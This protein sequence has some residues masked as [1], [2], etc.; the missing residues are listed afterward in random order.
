MAVVVAPENAELFIEKAAGENLEAYVVAEITA[1]A[2][3]VMRHRGQRS[4][5]TEPRVPR[6]K[7]RR[8]A[9]RGQSEKNAAGGG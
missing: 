1:D 5:P 8:K 4:W 6:V 3:M 9:S 7:R 2:R